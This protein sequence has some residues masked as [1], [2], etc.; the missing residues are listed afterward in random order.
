MIAAKLCCNVSRIFI[1]ISK[2]WLPRGKGIGI[3]WE[4]GTDI[5]SVLYIKIDN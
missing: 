3:N 2:L 1:K 4:I 5:Y